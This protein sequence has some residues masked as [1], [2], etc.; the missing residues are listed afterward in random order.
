RSRCDKYNISSFHLFQGKS[1]LVNL[2]LNQFTLVNA[3]SNFWDLDNIIKLNSNQINLLNQ[4]IS[5]QTFQYQYWRKKQSNIIGNSD[6]VID[7]VT[8]S[9]EYKGNTFGVAKTDASNY[10]TLVPLLFIKRFDQDGTGG[11][12]YS[13]LEY[14][15]YEYNE[16][17]NQTQTDMINKLT[18]TFDCKI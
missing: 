9:V 10:I 2:D 3:T 13:K 17:L 15:V 5:N 11:D 6:E 7:L 12:G 1:R 4:S 8:R 16:V 18:K 14:R